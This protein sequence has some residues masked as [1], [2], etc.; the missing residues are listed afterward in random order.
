MD[1]KKIKSI[2]TDKFKKGDYGNRL[3]GG[4]AIGFITQTLKPKS[5]L[6]VGCG[7]NQFARIIR[8]I[9]NIPA[10]GCDLA[11][12]DADVLCS[13]HE[14]PFE[15]NSFNIVTSFDCIEHLPPELVETAIQEMVRVCQTA[16]FMSIGYNKGKTFKGLNLHLTIHPRDWWIKLLNKYI[17]VQEYDK[18]IWG[19]SK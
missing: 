18:Y 11:C 5:L 4:G 1:I 12:P 14:L 6:D 17:K 7:H 3:H 16:I 9:Y 19:E 2:Y 8:E 10:T 13:A 15:N